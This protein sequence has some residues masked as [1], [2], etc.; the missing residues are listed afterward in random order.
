M[1]F[2]TLAVPQLLLFVEAADVLLDSSQRLVQAGQAAADI[3]EWIAAAKARAEAQLQPLE[4]PAEL[5]AQVH[6]I[7]RLTPPSLVLAYLQDLL[8]RG[9]GPD[10]EAFLAEAGS[11]STLLR[12]PPALV[13]SVAL[14]ILLERLDFSEEE[15]Q[16]LQANRRQLEE[17]LAA[18]ASHFAIDLEPLR[19][20]TERA[21]S[22]ASPAE[23]VQLGEDLEWEDEEDQ[24]PPQLAGPLVFMMVADHLLA[25][26]ELPLTP[27]Q[28]LDLQIN[29]A[30]AEARY[31]TM[32]QLGY[33]ENVAEQRAYI[34]AW[35]ER[36]PVADLLQAVDELFAAE[37]G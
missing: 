33:L 1:V 28:R 34:Q 11:A 31:L 12:F 15:A 21:L 9:S 25:Q 36:T 7:L 16:A 10:L 6:G 22:S 35:L 19:A 24:P 18:L 14:G 37:A 29:R 3:P 20:A 13:A 8:D 17:T 5:R 4:I 30:Q 32:E 27:E 23:L 2:P 26:S